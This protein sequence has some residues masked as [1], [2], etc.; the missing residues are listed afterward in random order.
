MCVQLSIST[1]QGLPLGKGLA[2]VAGGLFA[3]NAAGPLTSASGKIPCVV[4]THTHTRAHTQAR[5]DRRLVLDFFSKRTP[6]GKRRKTGTSPPP[7]GQQPRAVVPE[8]HWVVPAK[9]S[10]FPSPAL[11]RSEVG[12]ARVPLTVPYLAIGQRVSPGAAGT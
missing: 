7:R 1:N 3:Q 12:H 8:G 9:P 10:Y 11:A 6:G 4:C 5:Q 2:D